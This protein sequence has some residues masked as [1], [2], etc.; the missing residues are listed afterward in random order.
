[1]IPLAYP[2]QPIPLTPAQNAA[3]TAQCI[4]RVH[5]EHYPQDEGRP[6]HTTPETREAT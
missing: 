6:P 5:D 1:M 4:T 3:I 2:N